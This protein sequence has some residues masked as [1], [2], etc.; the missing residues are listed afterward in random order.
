VA[1]CDS[2]ALESIPLARLDVEHVRELVDELVEAMEAGD[3]AAKSVNNTLGTLVVCL[4]AA[5]EEGAVSETRR[6]Q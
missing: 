5:L 3:L 1:G 4:N 6:G 2:G